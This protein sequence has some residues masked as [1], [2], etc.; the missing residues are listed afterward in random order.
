MTRQ[1]PT[2]TLFPSVHSAVAAHFG[3]TRVA[4][5]VAGRVVVVVALL[6]AEFNKAVAADVV[7]AIIVTNIVLR[8]VRIITLFGRLIIRRAVAAE[9]IEAGGVAPIAIFIRS[10]IALFRTVDCPVTARLF[11]A[12]RAATVAGNVVVVV[13]SFGQGVEVTVATN[14]IRA[15]I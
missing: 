6:R 8:R 14:V 3:E 11:P 13:A 5:A 12:S 4:A 1:W 7:G 2:V 10:V 9:F 15:V